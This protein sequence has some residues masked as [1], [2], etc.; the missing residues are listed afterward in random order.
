[1]VFSF[2]LDIFKTNMN[3]KSSKTQRKHKHLVFWKNTDRCAITLQKVMTKK[4]WNLGL[5]IIYGLSPASWENSFP[6]K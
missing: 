2:S 6:Q 1:M 4:Y 5:R 3:S